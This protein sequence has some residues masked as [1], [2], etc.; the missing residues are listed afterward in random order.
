MWRAYGRN[1]AILIP[2][3]WPPPT[4]AH[5]PCD[6]A[7]RVAGQEGDHGG[8]V[9]GRQ[10]DRLNTLPSSSSRV[11]AGRVAGPST[12]VAVRQCG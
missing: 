3:C 7:R 8:Y 2:R 1:I 9:V 6:V 11:L 10:S 4:P 5:N 12:S